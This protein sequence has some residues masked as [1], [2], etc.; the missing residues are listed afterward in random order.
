MSKPNKVPFSRY[1]QR[2]ILH[3]LHS[4]KPITKDRDVMDAWVGIVSA[5]GR[6]IQ[7]HE[8]F[9]NL[10]TWMDQAYYGP[11]PMPIKKGGT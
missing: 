11:K 2:I 8:E 10:E 5:I 1:H 9:F 4:S 7:E 6:A 3:A